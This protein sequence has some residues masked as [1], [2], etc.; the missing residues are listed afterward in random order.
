MEKETIYRKSNKNDLS[1][2]SALLK[3]LDLN[4]ANII[5]DGFFVAVN[6]Q[7]VLG[8]A[9]IIEMNDGDIELASMAVVKECRRQ[10]I[11]SK[12]IQMLLGSEKRRPVYLMCRRRN[13]KF[14]EK[15]GFREIQDDLLPAVYKSK[16]DLT[17]SAARRVTG[18][19][20]VMIKK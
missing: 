19:G 11:G 7:R 15:Q 5:A 6:G 3:A 16:V 10:G 17:I 12:I 1:Q 2:I 20:L 13:Q 8:C 18:D 4:V 14:Y 9:R